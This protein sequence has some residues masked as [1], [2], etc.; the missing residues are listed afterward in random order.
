MDVKKLT[1]TK[2]KT[3]KMIKTKMKLLQRNIDCFIDLTG[4]S[5]DP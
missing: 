4:L 3:S 5:L 2:K 1:V